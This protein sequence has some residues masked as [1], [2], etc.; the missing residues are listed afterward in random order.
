M[1]K[2]KRQITSKIDQHGPALRAG[3][4]CARYDIEKYYNDVVFVI[5]SSNLLSSRLS[6]VSESV[7]DYG[8]CIKALGSAPAH[9]WTLARLVHQL[10]PECTSSRLLLM[11]LAFC[12]S[13]R[14]S[15]TH[16]CSSSVHIYILCAILSVGHKVVAVQMAS[17]NF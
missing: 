8:F 3:P 5:H 9:T 4:D 14:A 15:L 2:I 6:Y 11:A 7:F 17:E 10:P 12:F 1:Q 13:F 16:S